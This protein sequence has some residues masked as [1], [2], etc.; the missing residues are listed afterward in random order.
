[1]VWQF[2]LLEIRGPL[3]NRVNVNF[4]FKVNGGIFPFMPEPV[5][6]ASRF[7]MNEVYPY[8]VL[9]S[10]N[11]RIQHFSLVAQEFAF[12]KFHVPTSA[13]IEESQN[14]A[15]RVRNRSYVG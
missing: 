1:M 12:V 15:L 3:S 4:K 6:P 13:L 7:E 9:L 5:N 2:T 10:E 14:V 8:T 11:R